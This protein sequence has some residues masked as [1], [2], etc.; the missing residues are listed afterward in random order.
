MVFKGATKMNLGFFVQTSGGT[1]QN[2]KIYK[3]LNQAMSDNELINASVFFNDTGYNPNTV[4]FGM[5]NSADLWSFKGNLICTT[6]ENLRRATSIVNNI[7][8]VY[9]FS[10]SENI[11]RNL[12]D[13]I[14]LSKTYKVIVENIVDQNTF[15]RLT[16]AKPILVEDWSVSK[17]KEVFDE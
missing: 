3:F 9:L 13:F 12:F 17:L 4:K 8:L 6:I 7:K 11:E 15:Y 14:A 16:G 5:F 10:A 1:P 2:T